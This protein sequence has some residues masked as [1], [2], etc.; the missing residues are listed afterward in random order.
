MRKYRCTTTENRWIRTDRGGELNGSDAFRTMMWDEFGYQPQATGA[1]ASSQNGAVGRG[2]RDIAEK[3]RTLLWAASLDTKYWDYALTHIIFVTNCIT[4]RGSSTSPYEQLTGHCPNLSR[5]RTWGCT[6]YCKDKKERKDKT[7]NNIV[8]GTFLGFAGTTKNAVYLCS[9]TGKIRYGTHTRFDEGNQMDTTRPPQA[10]FL[11]RAFGEEIPPIDTLPWEDK[12]D[13]HLSPVPTDKVLH[14]T[15]PLDASSPSLGLDVEICAYKKRPNIKVLQNGAFAKNV[16]APTRFNFSYLYRLHGHFIRSTDDYYA[17]L[18]AIDDERAAAPDTSLL[19]D[20]VLSHENPW[21]DKVEQDGAPMINMDQMRNIANNIYFDDSD[22]PD[23]ASTIVSNSTDDEDSCWIDS[24]ENEDVTF[25]DMWTN[26]VHITEKEKLITPDLIVDVPEGRLTR[27]RLLSKS[28]PVVWRGCE[29]DQLASHFRTGCLGLPCRPPPGSNIMKFTWTYAV[30][31]CGKAKARCTLNGSPFEIRRNNLK[32]KKTY[33][34][35]V[36]QV[37]QKIFWALTAIC[38][39]QAVGIDVVNGYAHAPPPGHATF[40]RIDDQY[41]EWYHHTYGTE[42]DRSLVIP[43]LG[44]LQGHPEAGPAFSKFMNERLKKLGLTTTTHEPCIYRGMIQGAEVF[45]LRQV[46]DIAISSKSTATTQFIIDTLNKDMDLTTR[47]LLDNKL[48]NGMDIEQTRD[49]VRLSSKT[50]IT[51]LEKNHAAWLSTYRKNDRRVPMGAKCAKHLLTANRN[52]EG[53]KEAKSLEKK[54][55]F[56]YRGIIGELIFAFVT[57]RVDIGAAVTTLAQYNTS[58]GED[59]YRAAQQVMAYIVD[60]KTRGLIYWRRRPIDSLPSRPMTTLRI[61]HIPPKDAFPELDASPYTLSGAVDCSHATALLG[62]SVTGALFWLGG[63]LVCWKNKV[64][65]VV[66]ISSTEGEL[67]AACF[68]GKLIKLLRTICIQI[69]FPQ[70]RATILLEDNAATIDIINDGRP[71]K[72]TR[73]VAIQTFAVQ[74]WRMDGSLILRKIDTT[75]NPSDGCT[76]ALDF[77]KFTRHVARMMGLH[78]PRES[79]TD[80]RLPIRPDA[81]RNI[82]PGLT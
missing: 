48:Y 45:I 77:T 66:A 19:I 61:D 14:L 36:D 3:F 46:D 40:I 1:H 4:R 12:Y 21:D 25:S 22:V 65:S 35:C 41:A 17:A 49:F 67:I 55:G 6:V 71:T 81:F 20:I 68:A 32:I 8:S 29:K 74:E 24:F 42:I 76:K 54:F 39:Y 2:N 16:T 72:R 27:K 73:H 60:T 34:A 47:G 11:A 52:L 44:A 9:T 28:D 31:A 79:I 43:V 75:A 63:H 7:D 57:T 23:A 59:H 62:R 69:G 80:Y 18:T 15:V 56:T 58:P 51:K 37:G 13:L 64:Q 70:E 38:G 82:I 5:L 78:G 10:L 33:A 50:Y 30:K 53:S 26:R